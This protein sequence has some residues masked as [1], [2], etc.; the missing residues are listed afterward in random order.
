SFIPSVIDQREITQVIKRAG[1]TANPLTDASVDIEQEARDAEIRHQR[2]LL[3]TGLIFT[4]PLFIL[5]MG[6][7]FGLLPQ[8]AHTNA[9]EWAMLILA[10]PVQ[11]YVGWQYYE[12]A[13]KALRN[14]TANMDD[15][16]IAM[17]SS[18][19]YVFSFVVL[20]GLIPGHLYFE[21]A[22]VIITLIRLGKYLEAR[23]KGRTSQA[24]RK[25]MGLQP[26]TARI[27]RGDSFEEIAIEDIKVGDQML[28]RPGE[29]FAVDGI[30]VEGSSSVDESM[31]TGES[32]PVPKTVGDKVIGATLNKQGALQYSAESIG[33]DTVLANIIRL[34][35]DAQ[36]SKQSSDPETG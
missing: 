29:K 13:Y 25:L 34:V 35:Q 11:F 19:A 33:K 12:G 18:V 17:G 31:I 30:V 24:I 26:K 6:R 9:A 8:W 1:F 20:L 15:V 22:A 10:T 28:V 14:M 32:M 4:I 21:T 23:A 36:A 5:S 16:L 2:N 7:D 3:I 27:V